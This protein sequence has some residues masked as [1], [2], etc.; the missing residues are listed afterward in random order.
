MRPNIESACWRIIRDGSLAA[1]GL[2]D[3]VEERTGLKPGQEHSD[4]EI[5]VVT[6]VAWAAGLTVIAVTHHGRRLD[7]HPGEILD[8]YFLGCMRDDDKRSPVTLKA[9]LDGMAMNANVTKFQ[10]I[11]RRDRFSTYYMV[12]QEELS[13][14][15]DALHQWLYERYQSSEWKASLAHG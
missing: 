10:V 9:R 6:V 4:H 8:L 1:Q 7:R 3:Q 5:A 14:R 12:P 2:L 11:E 13:T 15:C